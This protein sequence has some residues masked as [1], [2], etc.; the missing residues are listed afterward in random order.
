MFMVV[1]YD[2]EGS[3]VNSYRVETREEAEELI[4]QEYQKVNTGAVEFVVCDEKTT[5]LK[6]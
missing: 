3:I 4:L 6:V 5:V 2:L 1:T